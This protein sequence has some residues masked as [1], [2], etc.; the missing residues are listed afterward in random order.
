MKRS[1]EKR[2]YLESDEIKKSSIFFE[3]FIVDKGVIQNNECITMVTHVLCF[4]VNED[5]SVRFKFNI[6]SCEN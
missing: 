2:I 1:R 3:Y 4:Q 6:K 5:Q